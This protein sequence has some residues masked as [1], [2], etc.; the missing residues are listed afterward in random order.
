MALVVP[1]D[2]PITGL[3]RQRRIKCIDCKKAEEQDIRAL[4]IGI[5]NIMPE[6]EKYEFSVLSPLGRSIIQI[7]PVWIKASQHHYI[8]SDKDHIEKIYQ[9]F[10][11]AI[12]EEPLDGLIITGAPV[13]TMSFE[14][15]S[16]WGEIN[17]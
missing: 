7:I 3:L 15:V 9:T 17:L 4:R 12:K 14:D 13:E 8:S 16:Y 10:E 6:A 11:Q 5:F 2:Y 1:I